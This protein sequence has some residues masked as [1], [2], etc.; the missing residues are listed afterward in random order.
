V[1]KEACDNDCDIFDKTPFFMLSKDLG[2][3][4]EKKAWLLPDAFMLG[5]RA[6]WQ[7]LKNKLYAE[8]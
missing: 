2:N 4:L 7:E 3:P 6:E 1:K 5:R 8:R